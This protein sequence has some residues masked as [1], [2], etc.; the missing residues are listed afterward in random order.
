[1]RTRSGLLAFPHKTRGKR[2]LASIVA[3]SGNSKATQPILNS[4]L[5]LDA[6][7]LEPG[8]PST[9]SWST[10]LSGAWPAVEDARPHAT[11]GSHGTRQ[12]FS[13]NGALHDDDIVTGSGTGV[14]TAPVLRLGRLSPC[15]HVVVLFA[16]LRNT[17]KRKNHGDG[18]RLGSCPTA[19][20]LQAPN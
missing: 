14:K 1:M 20:R 11:C 9:F 3:D 4:H 19:A 18:S 5:K 12:R 8:I 10:H 17:R 2:F 15:F 7:Y 13:D 16:H 6:T